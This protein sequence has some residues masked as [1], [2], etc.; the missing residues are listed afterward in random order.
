[1]KLIHIV[2]LWSVVQTT[3]VQAE[4]KPASPPA[5][6][7]PKGV[8]TAENCEPQPECR[9]LFSRLVPAAPGGGLKAQGRN[10]SNFDLMLRADRGELNDSKSFRLPSMNAPGQV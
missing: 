2:F 4:D 9:V 7:G 8:M 6:P 10:P 5:A 3:V 1:M